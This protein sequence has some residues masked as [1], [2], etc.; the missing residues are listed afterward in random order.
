MARA[1]AAGGA[2]A[3]MPRIPLPEFTM[4][5]AAT[6]TAAER[7]YR[8]I[9]TEEAF[10]TREQ[11]SLYRQLLASGQPLDPG[12]ESLW[13]FYLG[14]PSERARNIIDRLQ[15]LGTRRIADMDAS[16][17]DMQVLAL[18]GP[19][20]QVFDAPTAV[21]LARS[22]NDELAAAIR[23]NPTRLAGLAACA[24]QDPQAAARE[25]ER[26]VRQLKLNGVII[27]SHTHSEYLDDEKFW[28]IFEAAEALD[29]PIYLHPSGC[30]KDMIKPFVEAGLDG[31]VYGFACETGLHML[32]IIVKG[33]FDRFPKL[34]MV[35]GHCGEALPFWEYRINYMHRATV[36]SQR[37]SFLKPLKKPFGE[38]LRENI[39][40]TNSGVA[41]VPPIMLCHQVMGPDHLL[42]A[43]DYP[44]Q[45]LPEEVT[46]SD[47]LPMGAA[48]KKKYFQTNAE[49]L[50]KLR[51]G[52]A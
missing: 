9:A 7:G 50:F 40:V 28:P 33:V 13:G 44:Y 2:C 39:Y 19:G 25:I 8:R 22:A 37:Y 10:A 23:A 24:P 52:G 47:N 36:A 4:S 27:N 6:A 1:I 11:I 30:S 18:T 34:K 48:D 29:A 21:A 43:M 26:G 31:A 5:A 14:S 17:I 12:F 51:P 49:R 20:V 46:V 15:D 41:D 42:Y 32:R 3:M 16:G 35:I 45:Y 38:Y